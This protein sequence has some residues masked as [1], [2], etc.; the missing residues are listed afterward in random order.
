MS[1]AN[2]TRRL[3]LNAGLM[4]GAGIALVGCGRGD[5]VQ[6][7]LS[8]DGAFGYFTPV[9]A[10]LL[11]DVADIMIPQTETAGALDT[12]TI[13]YLDQLMQTW[14]G[15]ATKLEVA[16][17]I[18]SLNAYAR[19]KHQAE[20]LA[21]TGDTRRAFLAEIDAASFSD[22]AETLPVKSYRRVK[23]LIFHIHYT[24]EAANPDFILIP[25]QYRGDISESEYLELVEENRY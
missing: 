23:Q 15:K 24:S 1:G 2:I 4:L 3:V 20:Y 19:A 13:P 21:V 22:E 16:D 11:L 7:E 14:A 18:D 5:E 10:K 8:D 12:G 25:G 9:Q 6:L 17:F